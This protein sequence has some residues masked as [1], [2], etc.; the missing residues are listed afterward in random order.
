MQVLEF[1]IKTSY[2]NEDSIR[3]F[4]FGLT[5]F[6]KYMFTWLHVHRVVWTCW[7][8]FLEKDRVYHLT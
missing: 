1:M 2:I 4:T 5:T 6:F 7:R 3:L 8:F